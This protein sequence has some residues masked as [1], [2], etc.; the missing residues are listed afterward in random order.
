MITYP[1]DTDG[2]DDDD[3]GARQLWPWPFL[4]RGLRRRR[5]AEASEQAT[6]E[7]T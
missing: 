2:L 6:K 3:G 5:E 1:Y 7:Q 4:S